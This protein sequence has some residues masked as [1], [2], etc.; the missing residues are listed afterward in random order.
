MA[1]TNKKLPEGVLT[2]AAKPLGAFIQPA[3]QQTAGAAKPSLLADVPRITTLQRASAG[4]VQGY[5]KFQQLSEAL[6]P[7][8]KAAVNTAAQVWQSHAEGGIREGFSEGSAYLAAQNQLAQ[9]KLKLQKQQELGLENSVKDIDFLRRTDPTAADILEETNPWR[10]VGRRRYLAQVMAAEV[11]DQFD[12]FMLDNQA[13]IGG[14]KPGSG[15][16]EEMLHK[17]LVPVMDKYGFTGDET[18]YQYYVV[19]KLNKAKD[20]FRTKHTKLWNEQID[21]ETVEASVVAF[22]TQ[23]TDLI[24]NGIDLPTADGETEN[25]PVT[26]LRFPSIA[27]AL[28]TGELDKNL[29]LLTGKRRKQALDKIY[30]QVIS[31]YGQTELAKSII[32]HIKGGTANDPFDKRP[33]LFESMPYDLLKMSNKGLKEV[34]DSYELTQEFLERKLDKLFFGEGGPGRLPAGSE[35]Q[36]V[37]LRDF[38][39]LANKMGFRGID[40]YLKPKVEAKEKVEGLLTELSTEQ[41]NELETY[42]RTL[43]PDDLENDYK[44]I[45]QKIDNAVNAAPKNKRDTLRTRLRGLLADRENYLAKNP[46]V[47]NKTLNQRLP[48]IMSKPEI[49][50]LIPDL[51]SGFGFLGTYMEQINNSGKDEIIIFKNK[52]AT[53]VN[54]EFEKLRTQ[55]FKDTGRDKMPESIAQDLTNQAFNTYTT[56]PEYQKLEDTLLGKD[57]KAETVVEPIDPKIIRKQSKS[58][59][60][61]RIGSEAVPDRIVKRYRERATMNAPWLYSELKNLNDGK[62]FSSELRKFAERTK[63]SPERYLLEQLRFYRDEGGGYT[64]DPTGG[65]RKYLEQTIEKR[66]SLSQTANSFF[67][68]KD[69]ATAPLAIK[70]AGNPGGWLIH[71]LLGGAANATPITTTTGL[72]TGDNNQRFQAAVDLAEKL[73]AKYPEAVAAQFAKESDYGRKPSGTNNFFGLKALPGS[74]GSMVATEEDDKTG[75]SKKIKANFINFETPEQS[76]KYLIDKWYK[77]YKQFTGVESGKNIT[78]V[79]NLLQQQGYATD[80]NYAK[81]LQTLVKQYSSPQS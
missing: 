77:D 71:M 70:Q 38:R 33:Y 78:E 45:N 20:D 27:G 72:T 62:A 47:L 58:E 28:L 49:K 23:I 59:P 26:D 79:T 25:M 69:I 43:D 81:A 66:K 44:K 3:Q 30:E 10:L 80:P 73:G 4:S 31:T 18:E 52:I 53:G 50:A 57:K 24:K 7:F 1:T 74:K 67:S 35:E 39:E 76:F 9:A 15:K 65:I 41:M 19:P 32:A 17:M 61:G 6:G 51:G 29:K 21:V 37:A 55:W 36:K 5:N 64:F 60:V 22:G 12:A 11:D 2:P 46:P 42:L 75:K 14:T 13:E 56:S 54:Q 40:E 16:V 34:T 8:T 68:A 48:E 63:V